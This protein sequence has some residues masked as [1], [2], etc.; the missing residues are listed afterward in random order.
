MSPAAYESLMKKYE[1]GLYP[2]ALENYQ[3]WTAEPTIATANAVPPQ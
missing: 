2:L 3:C 1:I